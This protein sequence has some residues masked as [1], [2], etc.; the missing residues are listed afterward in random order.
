M[1]FKLRKKDICRQF[2][3]ILK[4]SYCELQLIEPY[5]DKLGYTSGTYG[6]NADVYYINNAMCLVTGYRAFGNL[7]GHKLFKT[8]KSDIIKYF[9]DVKDYEL[10]KNYINNLLNKIYCDLRGDL[11]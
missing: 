2:R 10:R 11:K 3:Y 4:F 9:E 1:Y 6:W 5:L 8:I 7:E